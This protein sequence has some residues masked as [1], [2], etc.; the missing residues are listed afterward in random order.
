LIRPEIY[1]T[2]QVPMLKEEY[3]LSVF[4]A[5]IIWARGNPSRLRNCLA[6]HKRPWVRE[7]HIRRVGRQYVFSVENLEPQRPIIQLAT[8]IGLDVSDLLY[9]A[10]SSLRH[11]GRRLDLLP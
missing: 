7:G 3:L 2:D 1:S 5:F 9:T 4:D 8:Q 10:V 6:L 11:A